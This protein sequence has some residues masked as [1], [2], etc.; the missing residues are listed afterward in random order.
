MKTLPIYIL[1][2]LVLAGSIL[3]LISPASSAD[4]SVISVETPS[5]IADL[6]T[7]RFNEKRRIR[8]SIENKE[9]SPLLILGIQTSCECTK[10]NWSKHPIKPGETGH[11]TILFEPNSL[12]TF[13]KEI[14]WT[15]N[16][17]KA[18]RRLQIKG[19]ILEE[20][21]EK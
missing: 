14:V 13:V 5:E 21:P 16:V 2:L 3:L 17:G 11:I 4:P 12:G 7:L 15:A 8:F 10:A 19:I 18:K 9:T 1:G 6:G 20:E